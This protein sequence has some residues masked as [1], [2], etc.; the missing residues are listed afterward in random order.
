MPFPPATSGNVLPIP[1]A[2]QTFTG[3]P[4]TYIVA[5]GDGFPRF[6]FLLNT[7]ACNGVEPGT[8]SLLVRD[9]TGATQA[10]IVE[11][12]PLAL[13]SILEVGADAYGAV[14]AYAPKLVGYINDWNALAIAED[15]DIVLQYTDKCGNDKSIVAG[16]FYV[17]EEGVLTIEYLNGVLNYQVFVC[18]LDACGD[19][20]AELWIDGVLYG[21]FSGVDF[22]FTVVAP[23][24]YPD[25]LIRAVY[26]APPYESGGAGKISV[27]V[28]P[29]FDSSISLEIR[30][31]DAT[32]PMN[33]CASCCTY[34]TGLGDVSGVDFETTV[35]ALTGDLSVTSLVIG[36]VNILPP[37][38]L[39]GLA[40][41][42]AL[43][44]ALTALGQGTFTVNGDG[45]LQ[46]GPTPNQYESITVVDSADPVVTNVFLMACA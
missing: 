23:E 30:V 15:W 2:N 38:G 1:E 34:V 21:Y 8:V 35:A 26:E 40:D 13:P 25:N 5:E 44:A 31:C 11:N 45:D 10:T 24:L 3:G 28:D 41:Q 33:D 7:G 18:P 12:T 14:T 9:D 22:A 36:G 6:N 37:G 32:Y 17:G 39:T 16:R 42:T 46:V 20:R 4:P 27:G 43:L 29:G 19:C